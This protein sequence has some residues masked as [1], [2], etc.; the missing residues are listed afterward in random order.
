[1]SRAS[2]SRSAISRPIALKSSTSAEESSSVE[3]ATST[4]LVF[5]G[6][7]IDASCT[8]GSMSTLAML[9]STVFTSI[10]SPTVRFACGSRS[11]QRTSWPRAAKAPPRLMAHVVLPT[12]PFWFAIAM[13]LPNRALL[14]QAPPEPASSA[15]LPTARGSARAPARSD[16]SPRGRAVTRGPYACSG[17]VAQCDAA[18][19]CFEELDGASLRLGHVPSNDR[20][21]TSCD[22]PTFSR[23]VRSAR[24]LTWLRRKISARRAPIAAA[25]PSPWHAATVAMAVRER[26]LPTPVLEPP[27]FAARLGFASFDSEIRTD[28][29]E[30]RGG[31]PVDDLPAMK[32]LRTLVP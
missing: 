11:M 30:K 2:L 26:R 24:P 14:S 5:V 23:E 21:A 4:R 6:R 1:M 22:S 16:Y 13:I 8:F 32:G 9:R 25:K 19:G 12:P 28:R 20:P 29:R 27:Q 3:G 15:V 17:P 31:H 7:T 18:T 10:P